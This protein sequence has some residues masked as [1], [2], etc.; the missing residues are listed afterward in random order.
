MSV[1]LLI[2]MVLGG[3]V[4]FLVS[5]GLGVIFGLMRVINFAHG[6]FMMV[7]AYG[8]LVAS[9]QGISPWVSIPVGFLAGAVLGLIVELLFMRR[10]Y[11]RPWDDTI[12]ATLGLTM[13]L[14]AAVSLIFG[15]ESQF[16]GTPLPSGIDLGIAQV[17]SYRLLLLGLALLLF[18]ALWLVSQRTQLGLVARAVIVN[19]QLAATLG[20]NT[21]RV[22]QATFVLGAALAALAGAAVAPLGSVQPSMGAE[23]LVVAFMVVLVAGSSLMSLG[24]VAFAY[25]AA[26]SFVT[27]HVSPIVGNITLIVLTVVIMRF[28]RSSLE[29]GTV[30]RAPVAAPRGA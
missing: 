10:L 12:F 11:G 5:C 19:E 9:R 13:A 2:N 23:Y 29:E 27:F 1:Q 25:G 7:G 30:L 3:S 6:A 17:S 21:K 20:V 15:R 14:V 8:A 4:V 28:R 16:V 22:R 24:V 18:A 26:E